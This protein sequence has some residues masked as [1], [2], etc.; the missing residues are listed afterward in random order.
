MTIYITPVV[1]AVQIEG[2]PNVG[3]LR[4][5]MGVYLEVN[6]GGDLQVSISAVRLSAWFQL[7]LT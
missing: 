3:E 2:V 4:V 6:I 1:P 7:T 5:K